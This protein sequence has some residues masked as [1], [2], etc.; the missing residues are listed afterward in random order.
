MLKRKRNEL[1]FEQK[2]KLI[3]YR[4]KGLTLSYRTLASQYNISLHQ[5]QHSTTSCINDNDDYNSLDE[6]IQ[7]PLN[8]LN[9]QRVCNLYNNYNSCVHQEI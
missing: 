8:V 4:E 9:L 5:A 2:L 7:L 1:S 3:Q 6:V